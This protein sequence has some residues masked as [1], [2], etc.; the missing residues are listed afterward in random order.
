MLTHWKRLWCWEGLGAGGEGDDRWEGWM[1]SLTWWTWV[2]VNLRIW[3]WTGRPGMLQFMGSQ[4]VGH[5]WATELN[6]ISLSIYQKIFKYWEVVTPKWISCLYCKE[7]DTTEQLNWTEL[8]LSELNQTETNV[9]ITPYTW[10]LKND[11][12]EFIY[13]ADSQRKQTSSYQRRGIN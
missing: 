9:T 6:W 3:W 1:A 10:N 7:S 11:A 8:M 2:W 13:K 5:N 4:R 12:N